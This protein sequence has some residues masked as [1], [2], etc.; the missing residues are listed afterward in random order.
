MSLTKKMSQNP[1]DGG[2]TSG[3]WS[4]NGGHTVLNGAEAFTLARSMSLNFIFS[5]FLFYDCMDCSWLEFACWCTL[6][7]LATLK[8]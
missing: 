6:P 7:V 2:S 8:Q 5:E 1:P 3:E 4:L